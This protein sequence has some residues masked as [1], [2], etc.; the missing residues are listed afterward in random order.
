MLK[1][2]LLCIT[3]LKVFKIVHINSASSRYRSTSQAWN[4]IDSSVI[5]NKAIRKDIFQMKA[6]IKHLSLYFQS[7][8]FACVSAFFTH[9]TPLLFIICNNTSHTWHGNSKRDVMLA[10]NIMYKLKKKKRKEQD[11]RQTPVK[12]LMSQQLMWKSIFQW[13]SPLF[14]IRLKPVRNHTLDSC[15]VFQ[16]PNE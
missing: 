14:N 6:Y 7:T 10:Y 2:H 16:A 4:H 8:T 11:P 3:L 15:T 12:F 9:Y 5:I 1:Y 13:E